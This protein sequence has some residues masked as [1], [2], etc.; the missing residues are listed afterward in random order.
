MNMKVVIKN[1]ILALVLLFGATFSR[2]ADAFLP[3][4]TVDVAQISPFVN[5]VKNN[6]NQVISTKAQ[7]DN[8]TNTIQAVGDQVGSIAKYAAKLGLPID[9]II[10][11]LKK[12][13]AKLQAININVKE[14]LGDVD[15]EFEKAQAEGRTNA[16]NAR[17]ATEDLVDEGASEEEVQE[18]LDE[19]RKEYEIQKEKINALLDE[20]EKSLK[21]NCDNAKKG[22]D[23]LMAEIAECRDVLDDETRQELQNDADAIKAKIDNLQKETEEALA[24]I[25]NNYNIENSK[26]DAAYKDYSQ[27][28]SDYYAGKISKEEFMNAGNAFQ[29]AV[30]AAGTGIDKDKIDRIIKKADEISADMENLK[31]KITDCLS[32]NKDYPE[33]TE[34]MIFFGKNGQKLVFNF[35][36]KHDH[37]VLKGVYS[38]DDKSFLLSKEL[39][40]KNLKIEEIEKNADKFRDCVVS[41]KT[42]K[43]YFCKDPKGSECNPFKKGD[44]V[45][46]KPYQKN[47]VYK[48]IL[49]DY[50]SANIVNISQMKQYTATWQDLEK[51]DKS[52]LQV[53]QDMLGKVDNTRNAYSVLGMVEMEG[54]KLWSKLRRVDA[55]H[56]AKEVVNRFNEMDTFYIDGRYEDYL[57]ATDEKRGTVD[58]KGENATVPKAVFPNV[59]LYHCELEGEDVSVELEDKQDKTKIDE[60]EKNIAGCL[61]KYAEAAGKG[62]ENGTPIHE[63]NYDLGKQEWRE[64]ED[65]ALGDSSF[66]TFVLSTVNNYKSS[67]DYTKTNKDDETTI[68]SL[69]EDFKNA[70][71]ARDDYAALAQLNYYTAQQLLSIVDADAQHLQTEIIK[72]LRTMEYNFFPDPNIKAGE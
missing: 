61:F 58:V 68:V 40:C 12:I 24:E 65:M 48:H 4:P 36:D 11:G 69:Q 17:K 62:T 2:P 64:K 63:D 34:N 66:E 44:G 70:R 49:E 8:M 35:Y 16:E 59:I 22:L 45:N 42:E 10:D 13:I 67:L 47:G 53:L 55:L 46:Y 20:A 14:I 54:P 32:N 19:S 51:G 37:I 41:A 15:A 30:N 71:T 25:R 43:T 23:V 31:E 7:I 27:A 72:D 50:S 57:N 18:S 6:I 3:W 9:K 39:S 28:I 21:E 52:T 26:M 29:S 60:A 1:T 5:N 33:E 56:R 38:K